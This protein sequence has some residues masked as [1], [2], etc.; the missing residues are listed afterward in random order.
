MELEVLAA[1]QVLDVGQVARDEVVHGNDMVTFRQKP[2]AEVG[3]QKAGAAGNEYAFF[4][5]HFIW[6]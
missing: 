2:V 4:I 3:A 5:R 1:E 6:F